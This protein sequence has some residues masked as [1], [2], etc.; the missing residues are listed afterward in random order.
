M[1]LAEVQSK[2]HPSEALDTFKSALEI[3]FFC[4]GKNHYKYRDISKSIRRLGGEPPEFRTMSAK[5]GN[6]ESI[7]LIQ[8][9][10]TDVNPFAEGGEDWRKAITLLISENTCESRQVPTKSHNQQALMMMAAMAGGFF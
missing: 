1:S 5:P 8:P 9:F 7:R 6:E 3:I 4:F 2:S 10:H